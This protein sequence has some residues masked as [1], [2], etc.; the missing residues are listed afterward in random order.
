M[1]RALAELGLALVPGDRLETE[2]LRRRLGVGERHRRLF[3][4]LLAILGEDG[5]LETRE[6]AWRVV[7]APARIDPEARHLEL[8]A[9][10]P[11]CDAELGLTHR[12]AAGLAG[13]MRG[14][15][16]IR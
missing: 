13:V 11:D 10:H 9:A 7:A 1:V 4:R 8:L 14:P 16:D 2:P 3:E 12:C 6:G 5:V 15:V